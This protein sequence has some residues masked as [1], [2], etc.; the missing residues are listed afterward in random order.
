MMIVTSAWPVPPTHGTITN[1]SPVFSL[2]SCR[3]MVPAVR[4]VVGVAAINQFSS[5]L[6]RMYLTSRLLEFDSTKE[7]KHPYEHWC[8]EHCIGGVLKYKQI[9]KHSS[10]CCRHIS[11]FEGGGYRFTFEPEQKQ[12]QCI[13]YRFP[14]LFSH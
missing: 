6:R 3:L 8:H 10:S 9:S 2:V 11:V 13:A 5:L 1:P 7:P 4:V 12:F 14:F